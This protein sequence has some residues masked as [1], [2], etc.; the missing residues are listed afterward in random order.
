MPAEAVKSIL[1]LLYVSSSNPG[2]TEV[3][4]PAPQQRGRVKAQLMWKVE[5]HRTG[6]H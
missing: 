4:R 6:F 1:S 5:M 3:F 2:W